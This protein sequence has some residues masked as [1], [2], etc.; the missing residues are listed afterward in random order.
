MKI[1]FAAVM[2][3][4]VLGCSDEKCDPTVPGTICT[5]AGAT[6]DEGYT[7]D[8]ALA[9]DATLYIPMDS[10]TGPDGKLWFIDFN[11]YVIRSIDELG[12]IETVIGTGDLGSSPASDMLD[13][14]PALESANNHTPTMALIG[15]Y[16]YLASWHESYIKRVRVGDMMMELFAGIA[17]RNAYTG[18]GGPKLAAA[19]DLP[20]SIVAAPNGDLVFTDQGNLAIRKIDSAGLVHTI[21][22]KCIIEERTCTNNG[23]QPVACPGSQKVTCGNPET[24]CS[25]PSPCT[26]A[27]GGDGGPAELARLAMPGGQAADPVGRIAYDREGNL[28]IAD[29]GNHRIRKV[30]TNGI[31]TTIAGTGIS[32]Y[33][34]DGGPATEAQLNR[35]VD[36]AVADDNTIYVTD[37]YN[38]CVRRIDT[39]GIMTTAAGMCSKDPTKRGFAGDGGPPTQAKLDRPYGIDIV[40]TKLYISDS[41]NNRLRVVNLE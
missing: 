28:L 27:F 18:D 40:G 34:G 15:D 41:Y 30:D 17:S 36:I 14:I 6:R 19:I 13:Q 2:A 25:G 26:Q 8:G 37:V 9:V 22:G 12:V 33:S 1:A 4:A 16:L 5:I 11:N 7:G 38:S 10:I 24:S 20:S 32:G 3:T 31:I 29:S 23:T 21:V 35:P 39:S